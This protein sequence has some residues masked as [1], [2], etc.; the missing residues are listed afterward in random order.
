MTHLHRTHSQCAFTL[1]ELAVVIGIMAALASISLPALEAV[2]EAG[3]AAKSQDNLHQLALANFAYAA[4]HGTYAPAQDARN[5]VRWHGARSKGVGKFD[6]T[7]GYLSPYL[8]ESRRVAI[9]PLLKNL[10][11]NG[12]FEEGTG[13]YGYNAAYIGGIPGNPFTPAAPLSVTHPAETLMIATTAFA[14]E[15][16]IQE[17]PYAEPFQFTDG[18]G[19][20]Q[21]SIHFR[22]RGR[23]LIAW[24]DGHVTAEPPSRLG[25]PNFYGGDNKKEMIGWIGPEDDNG[26]WNPRNN[27]P[28]LDKPKH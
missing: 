10:M 13:G 26:V 3:F 20:A 8:G 16:G 25:G 19:H 23:A 4:D 22:A 6:P 7:K 12:S 24:C 1:V 21:P 9:C 2:R 27:L 14:K 18:S 11:T 28:F 15:G 5:R 17:Y